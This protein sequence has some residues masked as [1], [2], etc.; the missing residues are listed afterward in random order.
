MTEDTT[1]IDTTIGTHSSPP[2]RSSA[3]AVTISPTSSTT[4][5]ASIQDSHHTSLLCSLC[6]RVT[7]PRDCKYTTICGAGQECHVAKY[8]TP[9]GYIY[10]KLGCMTDQECQALRVGR[11]EN[12]AALEERCCTN[13]SGCNRDIFKTP[14]GLTCGSCTDMAS[15][16]DC[17]KVASC[18]L[19][20]VCARTIYASDQFFVR[21]TLE[22]IN[23]AACGGRVLHRAL[24]DNEIKDLCCD[25]NYCNMAQNS[26]FTTVTSEGSTNTATPTSTK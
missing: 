19:S 1:I 5:A 17:E 12:E 9:R 8:V 23:R 11:R 6:D 21:Y 14:K 7:D 22:C 20:E 13:H 4:P 18:S 16:A 3:N 10:Y 15:P 25:T 2:P 24:S 26:K